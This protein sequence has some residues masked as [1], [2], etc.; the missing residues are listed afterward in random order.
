MVTPRLIRGVVVMVRGGGREVDRGRG[1]GDPPP[2]RD[3]VVVRGGGREEGE[4]NW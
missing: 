1:S 4:G 2:D 3:M